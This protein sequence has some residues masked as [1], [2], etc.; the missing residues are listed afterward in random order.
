MVTTF[1][2]FDEASDALCDGQVVAATFRDGVPVYFAAPADAGRVEMTRLSFEVVNERA[3]DEYEEW[4][5]RTAAARIGVS[6]AA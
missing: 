3:M 6:D 2:T 1:P 4:L 5:L